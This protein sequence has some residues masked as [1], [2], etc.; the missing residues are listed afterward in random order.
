[1]T[2]LVR[3]LKRAVLG[4]LIGTGLVLLYHAMRPIDLQ[5]QAATWALTTLAGAFAAGMFGILWE[6]QLRRRF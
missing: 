1:M 6:W 5:D 3:Q 2:F 4:M